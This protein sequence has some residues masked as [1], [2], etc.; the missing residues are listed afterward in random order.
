MT[1]SEVTPSDETTGTSQLPLGFM[2]LYS[3]FQLI[4]QLPVL[5]L[6][7]VGSLSVDKG[8]V[9]SRQQAAGLRQIS[10]KTL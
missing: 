3:E 4:A 8:D 1:A 7:C 2:G 6:Y 5:K 9:F 10:K